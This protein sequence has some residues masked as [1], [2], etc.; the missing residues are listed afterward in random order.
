MASNDRLFI[1]N[2]NVLKTDIEKIWR[3]ANAP[4][5]PWYDDLPLMHVIGN[6]PFNIASPLIIKF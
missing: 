1:H 6:L 5:T 4:T 2:A 3:D